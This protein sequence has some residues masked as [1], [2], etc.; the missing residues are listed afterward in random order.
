MSKS[1]AVPSSLQIYQTLNF[2]EFELIESNRPIDW[3]KV[4]RMRVEIRRKNLSS[5]YIVLCNSKSAS[6]RRYGCSGKKYG[7][8]DGQHRFLAYKLEEVKMFYQINDS[9]TLDDI[10]RAAAQQDSWKLTDFLHHYC[11]RGFGEYKAFK[12]YM[13][14]NK[15]PAATTLVI[16][17]GDRSTYARRKF[18]NGELEVRTNWTIANDFAEAVHQF[19]KLIKFARQSRFIEAYYIMFK[20]KE[21]DHSRMMARMEYM[22]GSMKRQSDTKLHLE[23]LEYVY[24]YKSREKVQFS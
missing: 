17:C 9:V 5:S 14:R 10:P 18:I 4:E 13:V 1:K 11:V 24:N 7:V 8:V 3:K 21:Y 15:F 2:D 19:S 6:K 12:G 22:A 16:L 20:N 23:Q